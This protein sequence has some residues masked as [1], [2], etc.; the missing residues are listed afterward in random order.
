MKKRK[1]LSLL[2]AV[3]CLALPLAACEKDAD[4]ELAK[5]TFFENFVLEESVKTYSSVSKIDGKVVGYS[6][7]HNLVAIETQ[8]V[9]NGDTIEKEYTVYNLLT[10]SSIYT[11][12]TYVY[13]D[14]T[15]YEYS[16]DFSSYPIIE[17]KSSPKNSS[18]GSAYYQYIHAIT[19]S[20]IATSND[21]E[22]PS[23]KKIGNL[24][25]CKLG[26]TEY[27]FNG[28]G[29]KIR[30]FKTAQS[31]SYYFSAYDFQ[32]EYD[33]YLYAW[34]FGTINRK[35]QV[36]NKEG[37]CCVN[38]NH[39]NDVAMASNYILNNGNVLTQEW[40]LLD[41]DAT[42][43][44]FKYIS[45]Q[46]IKLLSKIINY[47]TGDV[48]EV[49]LDY[50]IED[51]ESAYSRGEYSYFPFALGKDLQNQAYI[52][53]FT[54]GVLSTAT[55]YVVLDNSL[56]IVYTFKNDLLSDSDEY[57]DITMVG[58]LRYYAKT[59]IGND[60]VQYLF[61]VEGNIVATLSSN[62]IGAT[63][64]YIVTTHSIY[65]D[66][67]NKVYDMESL[68]ANRDGETFDVDV[69]GNNIY[70]YVKNNLSN[71][72][73]EVYRFD[74]ESGKAVLIADG[75][76]ISFSSEETYYKITDKES[77]TKSFYNLNGT[78]L[79]KTQI[80]E[81]EI[82]MNDVLLIESEVGGKPVCYVLK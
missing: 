37:V 31:D 18:T 26:D 56:N 78:V 65:D 67:G 33:D 44:S 3:V 13:T 29:D 16:F 2:M 20:S 82:V 60:E 57:E 50:Y 53:R 11:T 45:G 5:S 12:S 7:E 68:L 49:N 28:N 81:E 32:G 43:F 19:G 47:K 22:E 41:D 63:D 55:K 21:D 10:G 24:Y 71:T 77:K 69:E 17:V 36:F 61:D 52:T 8:H 46:K 75:V 27:W 42:D 51:L 30:T 62:Y 58:G 54:G 38:Y 39:P 35:I 6:E 70:M 72:A 59:T 74:E 79:L 14:G 34:E 73:E 40:K 23:V 66:K 25:R 48:T 15:E 1:L 64:K 80:V 9:I 4:E 76:G